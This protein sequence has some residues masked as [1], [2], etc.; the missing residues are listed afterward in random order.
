MDLGRP[1]HRVSLVRLPVA[2]LV[3]CWGLAIVEPC[4][5]SSAQALPCPRNPARGYTVGSVT[6]IKDS[7]PPCRIEFRET[8]IRL[9]AVAD[10]SRPDPGRTVLVDSNGRFI[11]ANARGW[12]AVISVWD[13]RGRYLSSFGG[14]GEGPGELSARG[15]LRLF[16]DG[17]DNLHVVHGFGGWS[18]FSPRLEFIRQLPPQNVVGGTGT[19]V[20]LDDGWVLGSPRQGTGSEHL[21]RMLDSSGSLAR[22]FGTVG[23]RPSGDGLRRISHAGGNTFWA[24]PGEEG[25]DAYVLEE[26]DSDGTLLRTLHRDVSWYRWRGQ[27]EISPQVG[28]LHVARSGLLYVVVF[29]PTEQYVKE[30]ERAQRGWERVAEVDPRELQEQEERMEAAMEVV[31]EVIDTRSGELLASDPYMWPEA[32]DI[33][34]QGLFRG[35]LRGYRYRESEGGLP[36]VEIV[37]VE[38]VAR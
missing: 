13:A 14:E 32:R 21:F 16:I 7:K 29:R 24:G 6:E 10:G 38:L 18:V 15:M 2:G 9:E 3:F 31:V 35:S 4:Y 23:D 25:A 1:P 12:N 8:G 37:S 28:M 27:S 17:R 22:T 26:W 30:Y 19:T 36:F 20:V 11:S 33:I 5:G 34:P